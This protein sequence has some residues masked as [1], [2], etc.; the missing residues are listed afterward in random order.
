[1]HIGRVGLGHGRLALGQGLRCAALSVRNEQ[2]PRLP[3][4]IAPRGDIGSLESAGGLVGGIL[5]LLGELALAS[6]TF[7]G[8]FP[9]MIEVG[10]ID[11]DADKAT[12]NED[13]G[14]FQ[15]GLE[16]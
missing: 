6:H 9:S 13:G 3:D 8:V 1:M 2:C 15:P 16:S 14:A 10:G 7:L 4:A 5:G 12:E 11:S